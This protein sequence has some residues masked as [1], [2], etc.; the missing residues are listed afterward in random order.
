M[1]F[2]SNIAAGILSTRKVANYMRAMIL[3]HEPFPI[4]LPKAKCWIISFIPH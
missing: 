1:G 3:I 2:R 4:E